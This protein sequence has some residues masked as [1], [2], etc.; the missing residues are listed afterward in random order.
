MGGIDNTRLFGGKDHK[1]LP[2]VKQVY[3][4]YI[5]E[6]ATTESGKR[7]AALY[8]ILEMHDFM[9]SEELKADLK[10]NEMGMMPPLGMTQN[11]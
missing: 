11:Q 3:E 6:H 2:E 8:R 10:S 7:A 1:L 4:Q 5:R 9:C